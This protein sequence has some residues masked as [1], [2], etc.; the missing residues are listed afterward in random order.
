M[1]IPAF[2]PPS[3]ADALADADGRIALGREQIRRLPGEWAPKEILAQG[4]MAKARLTGSYPMLAEAGALLD[5]AMAEAPEGA[6]PLVAHATLAFSTHRLATVERDIALIEGAAVPPDTLQQAGI[7]ALVGDIAFYRGDMVQAARQYS[8]AAGLHD[9]TAVDYRRAVLAKAQGRFA[10][11]DAAILGMMS[12]RRP[13][14]PQAL[15][16]AALLLG[17][18][19]LAQGRWDEA[20]RWFAGADARFPGYWLI[21]A[22]RAQAEALTGD[23]AKAAQQMAAIAA[24]SNS[25]EV[26]D[27]TAMLYRH[28]G[29]RANSLLW[30]K[31]AGA[32]WEER[33]RLLPE[34]AYGHAIEHELAFGTPAEALALARKNVALR[35]YGESRMLLA[36]AL[37][38]NNQP[39]KALAEIAHAEKSGWR[40]AGL[41]ALK[42]EAA[43]LAGQ[44]ALSQAA[45]A[46]AE[47][48]N[49]RIFDPLT[50]LI[51]FSHG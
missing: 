38:M 48:I 14:S 36:S 17:G 18:H 26:M 41:F 42:A 30:A 32:L 10:D 19:A 20:G 37:L 16:E 33:L 21:A 23:P 6:G 39:L 43:A 29:D 28:L 27:A 25:A 40:S 49:P 46:E 8:H 5:D 22:H 13:G 34:A 15:A 31:R 45:R 7:A 51:W 1:P 9:A 2:G 47:A 50:P 4:L 12:N 24:A 44:P 11:A 3:F 35:P